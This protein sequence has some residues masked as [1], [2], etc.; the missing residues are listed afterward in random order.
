MKG[1]I[2]KDFV[3]I[4]SQLKM[5]IIFVAGFFV[6][7]M[8]SGATE[9]LSALMPMLAV[10]I[11]ITAVAYDDLSGWNGF[12]LSMPVSRADLVTARYLFTEMIMV[13]MAVITCAE[14]IAV[15]RNIGEAVMTTVLLYAVS[16]LMFAVIMPI[17][18]KFG[19][20]K[21][22]AIF[23]VIAAGAAA[24]IVW[25][26]GDRASAIGDA[27]LSVKLN[28]AVIFAIAL[29]GSL[30]LVFISMKLSQGIYRRKDFLG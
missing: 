7:G 24:L 21:A 9:V 18:L 1:L 3:N 19:V 15:S 22:R 2:F 13:A 29:A 4:K 12:A 8:V 20:Q 30:L 27:V 17:I 28:D 10:L 5:Y 25:L 26:S 14:Y 16:N 23:M 11:P 6:L